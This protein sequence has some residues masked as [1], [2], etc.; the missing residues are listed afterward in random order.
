MIKAHQISYQ[1]KT[2]HILDSVDVHL[3]YGEFLAI[4]GPNGAGKSSLLSILP[5]KLNL[6]SRLYLKTGISTTGM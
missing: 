1:H 5:M 2:F 3:E 4:V 6:N